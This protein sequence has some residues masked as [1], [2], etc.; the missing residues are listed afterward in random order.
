MAFVYHSF[1]LM[2]KVKGTF[3]EVDRALVRLRPKI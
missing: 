1:L 2:P 3:L